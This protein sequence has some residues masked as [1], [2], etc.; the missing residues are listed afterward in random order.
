MSISS[1]IFFVCRSSLATVY[2]V[3]LNQWGTQFESGSMGINVFTKPVTVT[4]EGQERVV[5]MS[6]QDDTFINRIDV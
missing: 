6:W 4:Q 5:V 3:A 2:D 1:A